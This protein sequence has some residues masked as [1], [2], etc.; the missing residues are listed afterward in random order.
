MSW[1]RFN[2]K[3]PICGERENVGW[4]HS[5]DFCCSTNGWLYIN[6]ECNIKCDECID[7]RGKKP[8]FV[9]GWKFK[10]FR[11]K[12]EYKKPDEVGICNAISYICSNYNI[13]KEV[14]QRMI[15]IVNNYNY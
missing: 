8:S 2:C 15:N 11:H 9:L 6:E 1:Y 7:R 12:G 3:C 4:K 10:C 5:E 13:P 14:R